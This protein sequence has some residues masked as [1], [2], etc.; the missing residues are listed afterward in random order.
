MS[1]FFFEDTVAFREDTHI[2]GTIEQT[3]SDIDPEPSEALTTCYVHKDLP[4]KVR[5]TWFSEGRLPPGY[6]IVTFMQPYDGHCLLAEISLSLLDRSLAAGDVVKT[7]PSDAHSGTVISTSLMCSLQPLCSEREYFERHQRPVQ[8][9]YPSHGPYVSRRMPHH[10][11]LHGFPRSVS[12]GMYSCDGNSLQSWIAHR[13]KNVVS[14]SKSGSIHMLC[15]QQLFL[16]PYFSYVPSN[17]DYTTGWNGVIEDKLPSCL[18]VPA[19]EL[20]HWHK[21]CEQDFIIYKNWVGQVKSV[22]DEV[23]VRLGNGS[24]V[25]VEDPDELEE[26]YYIP[27]SKSYELAQRLDRA[28]F[29]KNS[30]RHPSTIG[31]PQADPGDTY[32][33]GMYMPLPSLSHILDY[34]AACWQQ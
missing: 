4:A 20:T 12:A 1:S 10:E 9:H 14:G 13:V 25:V 11:L 31:K 24:V 5:K 30:L 34:A 8:G 3:W 15:S 17:T 23:T 18:Q 27:G 26:P 7:A 16:D 33:P 2:T 28:G 6:V 19:G 29:Y 21:Y 22:Y 32:Y